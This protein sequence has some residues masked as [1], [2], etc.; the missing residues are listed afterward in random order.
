MANLSTVYQTYDNSGN[1]IAGSYLNA[2]YASKTGQGI[3]GKTTVVTVGV[4][5]GAISQAQLDGIIRGIT[6]G[7]SLVSNATSADAFVVIGVGS[8]TA[9]SSTSVVL[10]LNG[11]GT[12]STTTGQYFAAATLAITATFEGLQ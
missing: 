7:A 1:G 10:A 6:F 2:N 9:G 3:A 8:F 4:G 11:T 5:G 12:P